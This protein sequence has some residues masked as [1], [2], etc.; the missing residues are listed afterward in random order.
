MVESPSFSKCSEVRRGELWAIIHDE[1]VWDAV[2]AE[3]IL[4][5]GD[6]RLCCGTVWNQN[7]FDVS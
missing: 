2:A 3:D 5:F 6:G 1:D 7:D 4:Q